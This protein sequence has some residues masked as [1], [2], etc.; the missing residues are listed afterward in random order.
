MWCSTALGPQ[1]EGRAGRKQASKQ[2]ARSPA[3]WMETRSRNLVVDRQDWERFSSCCPLSLSLSCRRMRTLSTGF[4][5]MNGAL[6][7][8]QGLRT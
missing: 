2:A 8:M 1:A 3:A 7:A 5:Q 4:S 6:D